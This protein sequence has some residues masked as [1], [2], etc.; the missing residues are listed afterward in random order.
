MRS[1]E[2]LRVA[3]IGA[4]P[5]GLTLAYYL[6][7]LGLKS[8]SFYEAQDTVGGQSVTP[9]VGG[10]PVEMGTVYLT[11]GYILA[12]KIAKSVGCPAKVLP[13]ATVLDDHGKRIDPD[14]PRASLLVRYLCHWLVWYFTGQMRAPSRPYNALTFADWLRRKGLGDLAEGFAFSAGLTAQLYGPIEDIS[15]HSGLN[16]MRPTLF[17]T[18]RLKDV[19]HIPAGFQNMWKAL[20]DDL[21]FQVSFNQRI[22]TVRPR[23]VGDGYQVELLAG[24]TT[25]EPE[26]AP[27]A[28]PF[29]HVFI[30]CPLDYMES[31]PLDSLKP[32]EGS[33][34]N[35]LEH[36]LSEAL[37]TRYS[38]F[39][40]TEVYSGAW[41]ARQDSWPERAPSRCYLPAA[42]RNERGPLLTIRNYGTAEG[43]GVQAVGQF[44]SYAFPDDRPEDGQRRLERNQERLDR[45]RKQ[46]ISDMQEIVKLKDVKIVKERLWRYNNRFSQEQLTEGLPLFIEA[47]QGKQNVW[48]NGGTMSHWNIDAITD[49]SLVLAK[50][51]AKQ[52]G[53][54]L[55]TRRK[56]YSL[57]D[58]FSD[59]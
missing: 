20:W 49:Y 15:A 47:S 32:S 40:A 19:A 2:N 29:D 48:Y 27:I 35:R 41:T 10:I 11:D 51:F 53:L 34:L 39:A 21:G 36:P 42:S 57:A 5:S 7:A 58:L 23:R 50:R 9:D 13:P 6:K 59:F 28:E 52:I 18:A 25:D 54:P 33:P 24:K 31:H 14:S 30:A 38:P 45:N 1:P 44:C 37:R 8:V 26:G 16:W 43:A 12:R 17:L 46:V 3:I 22:D 4:G 56:I 55:R